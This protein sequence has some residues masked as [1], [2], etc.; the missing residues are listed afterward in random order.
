MDIRLTEDQ[1]LLRASVQRL[2]RNEYSFEQRRKILDSD[3]GCSKRTWKSFSELGLLAAP[4]SEELGGLGEGSV[5]NMVIMQEFGRHLVVEPY[6]ETVVVSGGLIEEAASE[7]QKSRWLTE[8]A[9]GDAILALASIE[10]HS[11]YDMA[12]VSTA[13]RRSGD[14]FVIDGVKT[15]VVAGG[16]A[17]KF[18]VTARTAGEVRSRE[19]VSMFVVD[20]SAAGLSLRSFRTLDGRRAAEV[21]LK[22]VK[23][24]ESA[25][26]GR[27]GS[28]LSALEACRDRAIAGLCAEAVGAMG[29][30]NAATLDYA[31]MRKQFGVSIGTFQVLQHRMVDMF[32]AHEE[33][34]SITQALTL[35]LSLNRTDVPKL[36]AAAK[37]KISAASKMVGEQA[38]QIHGGMGMTDELNVGHY[39]KRI[40]A[41][42][43]QFGDSTTHVMRFAGLAA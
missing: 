8:I 12:N 22:E 11:R 37:V 5:A 31:K 7:T 16:W 4:F 33:A 10:R 14:G 21:V 23:V 2:L 15:A 24:P 26:L 1:E 35:A 39:F 9:N 42:N 38:V 3:E 41:I 30:L 32:I 17:D 43:S 27:E 13:A 34:L 40:C 6:F 18:I 29:E 20:R 28:A 36:A 19:G 25:L